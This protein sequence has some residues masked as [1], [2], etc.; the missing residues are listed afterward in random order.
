MHWPRIYLL[1]EIAI[2]EILCDVM[3]W[4]RIYLLDEIAISEI[5][6]DVMH[7]PRIYLLDEIASAP[8]L[9]KLG[10]EGADSKPPA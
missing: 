5:L 4:P 6:C 3:H 7:W 10:C 8:P 1:D 9:R 2:S